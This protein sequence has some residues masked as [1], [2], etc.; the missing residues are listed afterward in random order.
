MAAIKF[1]SLPF[2]LTLLP[3]SSLATAPKVFSLDFFKEQVPALENVKD[4]RRRGGTFTTELYN[5]Q[6]M[7]TINVS[8][9]NP[10]QY[11]QVQLDTGSA[12]FWVPATNSTQCKDERAECDYYRSCVYTNSF[13]RFA[14]ACFVRV[15]TQADAP[16]VDLS[17]S[18][19]ASVLQSKLDTSYLDNSFK[20]GYFM[21]D[22]VGF[23]GIS[24]DGVQVG[25]A[26][27]GSASSTD[28]GPSV[29][30]IMGI[31]FEFSETAVSNGGPEYTN[32]VGSLVKN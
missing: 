6:Q 9:G 11:F 17:L 26:E 20:S 30:G 15:L 27:K 19:S 31:A 7:H 5:R 21:L 14:Y 4:L 10:P 28:L 3:C 24:M 29:Q 16:A 2:A 1:P 22:T 32:I 8:V 18:S 25:V 23:G 12:D 13:D